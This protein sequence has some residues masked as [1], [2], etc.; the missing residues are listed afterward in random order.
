LIE[1]IEAMSIVKKSNSNVIFLLLGTGPSD[2]KLKDLIQERKL[3]DN[4][5]IHDPVKPIEVPKY[6]AMCDVGIVPLPNHPYWRSQSPLKLLEYL[7]MRKVVLLTC[8]SAHRLVIGKEL[9]GIFIPLA[10]PVE[11]AKSIMYAFDNRG[12]LEEWGKCGRK[13][14][15]ED[16]T[17]EKI[18]SNFESYLLSIDNLVSET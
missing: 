15:E 6:V 4:V 11:I 8:I 9:C 14:V 16:Y 13:I 1:T 10:T 7:A 18:A 5:I 3:Q 12:K 2:K 17:W